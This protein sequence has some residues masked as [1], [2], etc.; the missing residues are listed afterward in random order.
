M[1]TN[2]WLLMNFRLALSSVLL[3]MLAAFMVNS[4]QWT[5][6]SRQE[7]TFGFKGEITILTMIK[8]SQEVAA[9]DAASAQ[10][11]LKS[12]IDEQSLALVYASIGDGRPEMIVF[13][14]HGILPWFPEATNESLDSTTTRAYLFRGMYTAHRWSAFGI[15]PLLPKGVEVSGVID[16][17]KGTDNLQYARTIGREL[18]PPGNYTINT[19]NPD[20]VKHVIDLFYQMG[21]VPQAS[22]KIPLFTYFIRNPLVIITVLFLVMGQICVAFDWFL[23]NQGRA[24]EFSIRRCYGALYTDLIRENLM[25]GIPGLLVGSVIGGILSNLLIAGISQMNL[26]LTNFQTF[27]GVAVSFAIVIVTWSST[28]YVVIKTSQGVSVD[29]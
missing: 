15:V 16:A 19:S 2:K 5:L 11:A 25:S 13:D 17:P 24:R 12:Y 10:N 22:Q 26:E 9:A 4:F 8:G 7:I 6:E 14:P 28:L 20:Q 27:T 23:Y 3:S 1:K 29:A 21:F 18:L